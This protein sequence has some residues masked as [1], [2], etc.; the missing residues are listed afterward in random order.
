[1]PLPKRH[2]RMTESEENAAG[3]SSRRQ[4]L[5]SSSIIGGASIINI[6][7]GLVRQKAAA[8]ILGAAG[9]GLV[10]LLQSLL[11]TVAAVASLGIGNAATRQVAEAVG[12]E[13]EGMLKTAKQALF[14]GTLMLAV[15]GAVILYML[16]FV[17]ADQFFGDPSLA[18]E[19]GWLSI[20]VALS[21]AG[22]SQIALLAGLRRV[23]DVARSSVI[24]AFLSAVV[25]VAILMLL[26]SDGLLLFVI[27]TPLM[28]FL[29]AQFYTAKLPRS[30]GP[31][32]SFAGMATQWRTMAGLGIAMTV[33]SLAGTGGQLLIRALLQRELSLAELGYFQAASTLSM[34]Y[35]GFVLGAMGTDYYPRLT[36]VI[37]DHPAANR[38]V[39]EQSEVALLLAGPV[40]LGMMGGAPW[41]LPLLYSAEFGQASDIFRWLI[42]ADLIKIA[43]FP[44]GF[45]VLASGD[46][47]TYMATEILGA[48][49]MVAVTWVA[50][51]FLGLRAAPLGVL[52]AYLAHLPIIYVIARRKIGFGWNSQ[53]RPILFIL[54][55]GCLGV[56]WIAMASAW[57]GLV[58][59]GLSAAAFSAWA[60]SRLKDA[61]GDRFLAKLGLK[62]RS[63]S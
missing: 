41:I 35:L 47:R 24:S 15:A 52:A 39:N 20:G 2:E 29:T 33:S 61:L 28:V 62:P 50:L 30:Q 57:W 12:R 10:G 51:P 3:R 1:M 21:M 56:L 54:L 42:L 31:R 16:R 26:G 11:A 34:T 49:I 18:D 14:W 63:S 27:S 7:L 8:L 6:F 45:V 22:S 43:I 46:G 19:V 13:D 40:L 60:F 38:L 48:A 58:A 59:G 55:V 44:L 25:G 53:V 37:E 9:V 36:A 17:I 23:G 4:I 32:V 5:R